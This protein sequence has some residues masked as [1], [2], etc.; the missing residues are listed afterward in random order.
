MLLPAIP[1]PGSQRSSAV[2]QHGNP[3]DARNGGCRGTP[4]GSAAAQLAAWLGNPWRDLVIVTVVALFPRNGCEGLG[5]YATRSVWLLGDA[6][7]TDLKVPTRSSGWNF[8]TRRPL[9]I[10]IE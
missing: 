4:R 5:R 7:I 8:I 1:N 10:L 2:R 6:S 3:T 9:C